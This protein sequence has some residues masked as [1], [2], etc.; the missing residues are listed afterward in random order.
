[1]L[2]S[3]LAQRAGEVLDFAEFSAPDA[4]EPLHRRVFDA[5]GQWQRYWAHQVQV[6]A[7]TG[8]VG[9]FHFVAVGI[10]AEQFAITNQA[11]ADVRVDVGEHG[12]PYAT[13]RRC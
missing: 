5:P 8:C 11:L 9:H 4:R 12:W 6:Q 3:L 1:M 7:R 10:H 2:A 13:L